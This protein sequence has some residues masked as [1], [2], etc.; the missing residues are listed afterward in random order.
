MAKMLDGRPAG[1]D[2]GAQ[3]EGAAFRL[4]GWTRVPGRPEAVKRLDR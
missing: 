3:G 1:L 2:F 4:L